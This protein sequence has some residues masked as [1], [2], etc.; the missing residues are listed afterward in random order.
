MVTLFKCTVEVEKHLSKK[1]SKSAFFNRRTGKAWVTRNQGSIKAENS[2]AEV[3]YFYRNTQL[4]G[5]TIAIPIQVTLIFRFKDYYT[6]KRERNKKLPDLDNLLC[7]PLDAL[8]KSGI[9]DDDSLV[10][11]FDG[12]RRLPG[13][14]N[15]LEIIIS[16]FE[17][18]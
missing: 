14:T 11:S 3:L 7:L 8:K 6:K 12:S 13:P 18:D 1:N 5:Q 4:Y 10:E 16:S 2:L 17:N 9:I 15:T